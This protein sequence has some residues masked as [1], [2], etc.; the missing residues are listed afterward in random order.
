MKIYQYNSIFQVKINEN[1]DLYYIIINWIYLY[2]FITK[3]EGI[4]IENNIEINLT[5]IIYQ[6]TDNYIYCNRIFI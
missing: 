2:Q 3:C 5:D 6:K 4:T 1:D